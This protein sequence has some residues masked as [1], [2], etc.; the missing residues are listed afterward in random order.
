MK[1]LTGQ[2]KYVIMMVKK[3]IYDKNVQGDVICI[4]NANGD[5]IGFNMFAYCGNNP[6]LFTD[7]EGTG[8]RGHFMG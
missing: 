5:I 7:L 8:K 1:K 6:I 4:L 2:V 3:G